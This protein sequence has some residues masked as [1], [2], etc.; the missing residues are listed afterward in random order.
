MTKTSQNVGESWTYY[1]GDTLLIEVSVEKD[2]GSAKD[3]TDA[4]V[5]YG[6]SSKPGSETLVSKTTPDGVTITDAGNGEI[7]IQIDP[8]D[9]EEMDGSYYHECEVTDGSG[10]VS[11]IFTGVFYISEDTV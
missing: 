8:A 6:I 4:S 5:E 1:S 2:D 9:T 11:T 3:L 7:E 10:E